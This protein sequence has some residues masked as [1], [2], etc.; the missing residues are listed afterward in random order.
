MALIRSR[1]RQCQGSQ[2]ARLHVPQG[3]GGRPRHEGCDRLAGEVR[4]CGRCIRHVPARNDIP[5]RHRLRSR[6]GGIGAL[7]VHVLRIFRRYRRIR[8]RG[9]PSEVLSLREGAFGGV[10]LDGARRIPWKRPGDV[11]ARDDV[12]GRHRRSRRFDQGRR[13]LR[14]GIGARPCTIHSGARSDES[15]WQRRAQGRREGV[16]SDLPCSRIRQRDRQIPAGHPV[17]RRHRD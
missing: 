5:R 2:R 7:D 12:Q 14:D 15:P 8:A 10:P 9:H 16:R 17:S 6:S 4:I 1:V 11:P 13:A 3:D